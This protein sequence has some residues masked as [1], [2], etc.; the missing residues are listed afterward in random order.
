MTGFPLSPLLLYYHTLEQHV[1]LILSR[2]SLAHMVMYC[3]ST[4]NRKPFPNNLTRFVRSWHL[5]QKSKTSYT[6]R[7]G[8]EA[9]TAV[10]HI[11]SAIQQSPERQAWMPWGKQI[12]KQCLNLSLTSIEEVEKNNSSNLNQATRT[13]K[14][15]QWLKDVSLDVMPVFEVIDWS[16]SWNSRWT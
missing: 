13:R 11:W 5:A 16:S 7:V 1:S 15:Q 9:S 14:M 3:R 6:T 12:Y 2:Q 4:F 8:L 10:D